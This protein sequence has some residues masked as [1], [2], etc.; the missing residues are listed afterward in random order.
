[1]RVLSTLTLTYLGLI[2][3]TVLFGQ[4]DN[5]TLLVKPQPA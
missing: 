2:C 3:E 5:I 4:I 1:L